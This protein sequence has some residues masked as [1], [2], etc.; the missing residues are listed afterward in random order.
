MPV[1]QL[2]DYKQWADARLYRVLATLPA[3]ELTAPQP[4]VFGSL[5]NTAHHVLTVDLIFKAHLTGEKHGFKSRRP[6][7]SPPI[8]EL[9]I[10]Q[11][12][13]D[14]WYVD[15]AKSL[16]ADNQGEIVDFSFVD[17]G[18]GSMTREEILVHIANHT[19]YHRGHIGTMLYAVSCTPPTTDYTVYL[20]DR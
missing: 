3:E 7:V 5:I 10:S 16:N 18:H 9:Q 15:Y 8:E 19:T 12:V 1:T 6:K 2:M 4:I 17:G 20:R 13:V 14:H 11:Q